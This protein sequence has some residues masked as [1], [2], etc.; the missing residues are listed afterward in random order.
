MNKGPRSLANALKLASMLS[1]RHGL[2]ILAMIWALCPAVTLAADDAILPPGAYRL[3]MIMAS[4]TR[5]RFFGTSRSASKS[6][7]LAG[8]PA[9]RRTG[10]CKATKSATFA[11]SKTRR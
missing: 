3:E 4:T 5:I 8:Y 10:S 2:P 9:R 6:V 7:S 11:F 1:R